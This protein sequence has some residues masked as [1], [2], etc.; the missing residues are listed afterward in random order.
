MSGDDVS[1]L[2]RVAAVCLAFALPAGAAAPPRAAEAPSRVSIGVAAFESVGAAGAPAPDVARQLA[3]R[4]DTRGARAVIGTGGLAASGGAEPTPAQVQEWAAAAGVSAIA[5]GRV[6]TVGGRQSIDVRLR[7]GDSGGLLGTYVAE[8][9][10]PEELAAGVDRLA[11]EIVAATAQW[12]KTDVAAAPPAVVA[13]APAPGRSEKSSPFGLGG[14][15]S[16]RPLSI[17][18]D[19]LEASQIGGARKLIFTH[20]VRVEQGDLK[21]ESA[22][23]EAFYPENVNQPDRLFASGGVH[24]VQGTRQA[25]CDQA[26]YHRSENRLLCE[27]HAELMDGEDSVAG[28]T[29]DF[30]LAAEKVYVR[31]GAKVL[32]HPKSEDKSETPAPAPAAEASAAPA[33]IAP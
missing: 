9:K 13:R 16:S 24:V 4:I 26:T 5:L 27:G 19:E 32:F 23:L 15:D 1:S 33:G 31:G 20:S 7:T 21:L 14:Y 3:D 12:L 11:G 28:A 29:I 6:T 2:W 25:R 10:S 22:R 8:A 17:Y 18:S 30:D